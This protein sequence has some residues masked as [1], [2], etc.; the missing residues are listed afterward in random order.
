[1]FVWQIPGTED[2]C[3]GP[4]KQCKVET[5]Q[6]CTEP[7]KPKDGCGYGQRLKKIEAPGLCPQ[8]ACVCLDPEDCPPPEELQDKD[9]EE[10]TPL[11][12][13]N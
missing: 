13:S 10:G 11:F 1:M 12:I 2:A 8:Y 9:L 4:R 3:C 5:P 7:T 6:N